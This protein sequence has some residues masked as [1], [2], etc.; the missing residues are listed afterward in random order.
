MAKKPEHSGHTHET[1]HRPDI[2]LDL[3]LRPEHIPRLLGFFREGIGLPVR[4]GCTVR[5]LFC[6]QLGLS[7]RYMDQ[8]VQTIFLDGKPVDDVDTAVVREGMTLALS[9]A[10]P[11]LAGA[12]LRKGGF[13]ADLRRQI[14]HQ[15]KEID[16]CPSGTPGEIR[17]KLFNFLAAEWGPELLRR[18]ILIQGERWGDFLQRQPADFRAACTRTLVNGEERGPE[19]LENLI[20]NEKWILLRAYPEKGSM[21]AEKI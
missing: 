3:F 12:T 6:E 17:L 15:E 18:G 19:I 13:F 2:R 16:I 9:A 1:Q 14:T 4:V 8:R 11:G 21:P 7:P 5:S 20:W 10:M